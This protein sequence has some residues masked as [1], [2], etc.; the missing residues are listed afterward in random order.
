MGL[1]VAIMSYDTGLYFSVTA[2]R[3][4]P[5]DVTVIATGIRDAFDE[6]RQAVLPREPS[7]AAEPVSP[8]EEPQPAPVAESAASLMPVGAGS[9]FPPA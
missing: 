1:A 7:P 8:R 9:A 2:D 3:E 5:G 4:T 6:I